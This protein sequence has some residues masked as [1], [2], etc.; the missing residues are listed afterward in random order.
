MDLISRNHSHHEDIHEL[1]VRLSVLDESGVNDTRLI[2]LFKEDDRAFRCLLKAL[3]RNKLLSFF[4]HIESDSL[5]IA[6]P[7]FSRYASLKLFEK[8]SKVGAPKFSL[9]RKRALVLGT[10]YFLPV[11]LFLFYVVFTWD[12]FRIY[13]DLFLGAIAVFIIMNVPLVVGNLLF[14]GFFQQ[15]DWPAGM[16]TIDDLL[17]WMCHDNHWAYSKDNYSRIISEIDEIVGD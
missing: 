1:L 8:E 14:D 2:S 11:L 13:P 16:V 3:L 5:N 10:S 17:D 7:R 9:S 15:Y 12:S 6:F 4:P